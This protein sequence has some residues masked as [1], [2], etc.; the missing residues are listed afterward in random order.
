MSTAIYQPSAD[1]V[2]NAHISGMP[3]Y[4]ALCKEAETDYE[5]YWAGRP[6]SPK[7]WTSRMR[8]FSNGSK[9]AL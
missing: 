5:G 3:A 8:L 4:E 1:F 6:P 9:T 7:C 2:K